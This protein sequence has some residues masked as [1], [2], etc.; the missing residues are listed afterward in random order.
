MNKSSSIMVIPALILMVVLS[1]LIFDGSGKRSYD[2]SDKW[3]ATYSHND[4]MPFGMMLFDSIMSATLPHGYRYSPSPLPEALEAADSTGSVSLLYVTNSMS[5]DEEGSEMLLDFVRRGNKVLLVCNEMLHFDDTAYAAE[6]GILSRR[7]DLMVEE[8]GGFSFNQFKE[9][10][11]VNHT[12]TIWWNEEP[13]DC[14]HIP[15]GLLHSAVR[16]INT[17]HLATAA[18]GTADTTVMESSEALLCRV[19]CGKGEVIVMSNTLLFTNYAVL[20]DSI[21]PFINRAMSLIADRPVVRLS[22]VSI[23]EQDSTSSVS[24][25]AFFLSNRPLQVALYIALVLLLLFA[26]FSARR[27]QR[28]MPVVQEPVNQSKAFAE[29]IGSIYLNDSRSM[30]AK[31]YVLFANELRRKMRIDITDRN[32]RPASLSMLAKRTGMSIE[33]LSH[34]IESTEVMTTDYRRRPDKKEMMQQIDLINGILEKI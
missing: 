12:D 22:D 23:S 17:D 13:A 34:V 32:N 19:K 30:V 15:Q 10:L 6:Y 8:L 3:I 27:R 26:C 14:W 25:L 4:D 31:K 20:S 7:L 5:A 11:S 9:S 33:Y 18:F 29:L 16:H 21:S 28:V 24:P 1:V 2:D